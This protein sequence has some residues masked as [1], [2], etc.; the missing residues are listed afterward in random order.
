M[1]IAQISQAFGR[2]NISDAC[3]Y[4]E[5]QPGSQAGLRKS[6]QPLTFT[7]ELMNPKSLILITVFI[8]S[9]IAGACDIWFAGAQGASQQAVIWLPV[10]VT[11]ALMFAWVHADS[12]EYQYSRSPLFNV[13]IIGLAIVFIPVYLFKSRPR[14]AKAKSLG[15]FF[16]LFL[17]YIAISYAG[18]EFA[19]HVQL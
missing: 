5:A 8:A 16:A 1:S 6:A 18:S 17:G 15:V 3:N 7:L 14:G 9:F 12:V 13:G 19:Y 4:N 2:P 11:S 10:I